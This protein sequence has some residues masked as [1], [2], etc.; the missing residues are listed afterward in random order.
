VAYL[1]SASQAKKLVDAS[2]VANH[3][4]PYPVASGVIR[5]DGRTA[6]VFAEGRTTAPAAVDQPLP[7]AGTWVRPGGVVI[8]HT[9]ADALGVSV[10]DHV[11]LDGRSFTVAGVAVTAAQSPY[12][13]LCNGTLLASTPAA[14]KFSNACP[15]SFKI[16]FLSLPG[17]RELASSDDVGLI[18]M[19]QAEPSG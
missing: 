2:G 7:T 14:S 6:D 12:P 1:T 5:F 15:P 17:G 13:N 4:G 11:T 3:S 9:F 10:G 19:T 16:P 8:E 18:W